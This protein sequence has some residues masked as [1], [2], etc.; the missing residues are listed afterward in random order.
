MPNLKHPTLRVAAVQAAPIM[1]DLDATID[2]TLAI[3]NEAAAQGCDLVA[4]PE[5]W[6][7]GYPWWIWLN[8]PAAGMQYVQRYFNSA[9]EVG[10]QEFNRLSNAAKDLGIYLSFGFSERDGGSLYIAQALIDSQGQLLK[11]R[12]K[13][14]PTHVERTVFGDG[15][16]SDLDVKETPLGR[17]GMLACW[18]HLQPLSRYAMYAQNEQIHITA[19]PSFSVY[20]GA[21]NALSGEVNNA[22]SQ[23][24]ALEGGCFVVAPCAIV[25]AQMQ[26]LLCQ[27]EE[28]QALLQ[29]GGGFARIY[30]PDGAML[31]KTLGEDEE[32]LVI[33]DI[34][35]GDISLA[36]SVADPAGH[37]ARPDVTQLLLNQ[38]PGERV[39]VRPIEQKAV[40][41]SPDSEELDG[42]EL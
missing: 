30:G 31:G 22:V 41:D 18:E 24:Y 5:T 34:D 1:F 15:D 29:Q 37:Y 14:K 4:F 17:I 35:L 9:L 8:N 23:V 6:I 42:T 26:Q 38:A 36:K 21:A 39:I 10:G 2:K 12:R 19:W 25:S 40:S 11:S 20:R 28:Q 3:M 7:P 13:L 33:A 16:G 27:S 32:G